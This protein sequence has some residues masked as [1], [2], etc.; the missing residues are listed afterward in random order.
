MGLELGPGD[1]ITWSLQLTE[2]GV[3][4]DPNYEHLRACPELVTG[5]YRFVFFGVE[6]AVAVGFDLIR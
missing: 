1:T 6:P 3:L 5:R 2:K 4:P